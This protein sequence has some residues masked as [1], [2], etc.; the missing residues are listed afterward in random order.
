MVVLEVDGHLSCHLYGILNKRS[1]KLLTS[2]F[3]LLQGKNRVYSVWE[4]KTEGILKA[5]G[6]SKIQKISRLSRL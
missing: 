2:M 1:A 5:L 6:F 4:V 3:G